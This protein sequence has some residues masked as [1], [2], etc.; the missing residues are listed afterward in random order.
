MPVHDRPGVVTATWA[1]HRATAAV[2]VQA[3]VARFE[4]AFDADLRAAAVAE[5]LSPREVVTLASIVEKETAA[6]EERP[7]VAAV[8]SRA[9][10]NLPRSSHGPSV[11]ATPTA[12]TRRP[13]RSKRSASS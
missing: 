4:H 1:T 6:S 10:P 7:L 5:R 13:G 12:S 3:M 2:A 11:I 9:P 8:R